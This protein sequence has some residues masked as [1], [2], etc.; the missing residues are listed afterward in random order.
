MDYFKTAKLRHGKAY[1]VL[2]CRPKCR[3]RLTPLLRR[4]ARHF[5]AQQDRLALKGGC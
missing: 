5:V 4:I 3:K 1:T 2:N